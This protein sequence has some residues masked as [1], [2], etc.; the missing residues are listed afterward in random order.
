MTT[1]APILRGGAGDTS[2]ASHRDPVGFLDRT[3]DRCHRGYGW[4]GR[5]ADDPGCARCAK[6]ERT[7][8]ERLAKIP[9]WAHRT[10][11]RNTVAEASASPISGEH[12][13]SP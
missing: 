5:L 2:P 9:P 8:A 4:F 11:P 7:R 6:A 12:S 13:E 1:T 3:C 10:Q